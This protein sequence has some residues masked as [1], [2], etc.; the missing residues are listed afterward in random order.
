ML[1][2]AIKFAY[3]VLST[4]ILLAVF[5][6]FSFWKPS[7]GSQYEM[8]GKPT[9]PESI[10][11]Y[12]SI[13]KYSVQYKVP[14]YIAYNVAYLETG[15]RGPFHWYYEPEQISHMGAVGPMQIIPRY[16]PPYADGRVSTS[17]LMKN[18]DLN[19]KVSMRMLKKWY[20]I[21]GNWVEACG[22]YNSGQ[23]I[24]NDYAI[25][26]ANNKNYKKNWIPY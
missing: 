23:P 10:Q 12:N 4:A 13:E 11:M 1:N 6:L 14:K 25:F 22:A 8:S 17:E 26:C 7:L 16:A 21:H 2:K 15:Y 24:H 20:S 5:S 9:S 19:V 18:I 3:F